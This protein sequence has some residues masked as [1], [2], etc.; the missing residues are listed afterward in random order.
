MKIKIAYISTC[1]VISVLFGSV[2]PAILFG[3][4]DT[5]QF[6]YRVIAAIT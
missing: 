6:D 2:K 3:F 4:P 5:S 1:D